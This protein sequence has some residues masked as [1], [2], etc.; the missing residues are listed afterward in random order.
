MAI[1]MAFLLSIIISIGRLSADSELIVMRSVGFSLKKLLYPLGIFSVLVYLFSLS[2]SLW[3]RP[4]SNYQLGLG[5]FRLASAQI[6]SSLTSGSFNEI[7]PLTIYAKET[8]ENGS[9]LKDVLISDR[10]DPLN[11]RVFYSQNA[12][13][14]SD[15]KNR[16]ILM[17]LFDG[18]MQE[19]VGTNLAKTK[20]A[21]NSITISEDELSASNPELA[22][23]KNSEMGTLELLAELKKTKGDLKIEDTKKLRFHL[24]RLKVELQKRLTLPASCL[25]VGIL[26]LALGIQPSRSGSRWGVTISFITGILMIL[27]YYVAFAL[28]SAISESGGKYILPLMWTPN[29]VF[30]I[31]GCYLFHQLSTEKWTSAL[32]GVIYKVGSLKAFLSKSK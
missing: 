31:I 21:L 16:T 5:L 18:T 9:I 12:R 27:L 2:M 10:R 28:V 13:F 3:I 7:G 20:Y 6:S 22:R 25:F 17:E 30:L 11:Q 23:K 32:D 29:I 24:Y 14:R 15:E 1:P 8:L 19:G 26:S 4:L